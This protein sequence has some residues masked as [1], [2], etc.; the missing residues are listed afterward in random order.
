MQQVPNAELYGW[1]TEYPEVAAIVVLVIG[2]IVARIL[3]TLSK[4]GLTALD[5]RWSRQ[6]TSGMNLLTP[7]A[8]R[9]SS[10]LLFWTFVLLSIGIAVSFLA[11]GMLQTGLSLLSEFAGRIALA[12]IVVGAGHLLGLVALSGATQLTERV[13]LHPALPRL[14]YSTIMVIAVVTALA[15]L[16]IDTSFI[17]TLRLVLIGATAG[18][19]ALAFAAGA[20]RYVEN[21][22]AGR[23]LTRFNIGDRIRVSGVEGTLTAIHGTYVEIECVDGVIY[24]P[25]TQLAWQPVTRLA[26]NTD[27]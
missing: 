12:I 21:L 16:A 10:T 26:P 3:Q 22:L 19:L 6:S 25:A 8:I 15:Q 23:E 20:R 24:L 18:A 13:R 2:V 4:R 17:A 5:E 9:F 14:A 27:V 7:G 11:P 1:V